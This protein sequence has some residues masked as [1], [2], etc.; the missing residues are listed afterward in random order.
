MMKKA[1]IESLPHKT[2]AWFRGAF[3]F[4]AIGMGIVSIQGRWLQIN[5]ALCSML[6][7]P[8]D[9][10]LSM[11]IRDLIH[12]DDQSVDL[13]QIQRLLTGDIPTY[14]MEKRFRHHQGH[15]IWV[16]INVSLV[17]DQGRPLY[18]IYQAQDVTDR[19][20]YEQKLLTQSRALESANEKLRELAATD[21][22]T[23]LNNRRA[24]NDRLNE[25]VQRTTRYGGTMS[26]LILDVDR[27][28]QFNDR[29][30]HPSGDDVLKSV[31]EL[32]NRNAR[33]TD[34]VAR[35]GGEEFTVILPNTDEQ[36]SVIVAER[37]R[38]SIA[39]AAWD[40]TPITVSLGATTLPS[41]F[42]RKDPK[43]ANGANL[44]AEAD[45]ALYHSKQSGRNR[46]THKR[47]IAVN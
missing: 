7:Y 2:D 3:D 19:K 11:A 22:L 23:G 36:G 14:R 17:R 40:K 39:A 1:S 25:E 15:L 34:F 16:Q 38:T 10:L 37:I 31:A 27:F 18:F 8:A 5:Q 6:G 4:A 29:F 26:L 32:M 21:M 12:P 30:G 20:A 46:I 43:L 13:V 45:M 42:D 35:Y 28:K 47:E 9:A 44:I 41:D 24:F 33:G